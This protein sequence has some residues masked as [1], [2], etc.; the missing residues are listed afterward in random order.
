VS[1]YGK[2]VVTERLMASLVEQARAHHMIVAV[3]PKPGN[4]ECYRGTDVVTPNAKET[5]EMSGLAARSDEEAARAGSR[6][7]ERL[8]TRAILVTRGE[9]GATLVEREG[10]VTHIPTRVRD[11]FDVTGAGDTTIAVLTLA[12]AAGADLKSAACLAN[13]AAGIVVGKLGTAV[14]SAAELRD[15]AEHGIGPGSRASCS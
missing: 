2:G 1:D 11:V 8:E 4:W 5:E 14:A 12:R 15:A 3:D 6:L 13:L 10:D 9:M 7:L